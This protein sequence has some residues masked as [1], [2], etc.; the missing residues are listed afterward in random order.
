MNSSDLPSD[1]VPANRSLN[2]RGVR[3]V[4]LRQFVVA[5]VASG[6]GMFTWYRTGGDT[7]LSVMVA[8]LTAAVIDVRVSDVRSR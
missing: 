8:A 3:K 1:L 6:M 4:S 7:A 2:G 5:V